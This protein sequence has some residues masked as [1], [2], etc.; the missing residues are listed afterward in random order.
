MSHVINNK[1]ATQLPLDPDLEEELVL[2][3]AL[4]LYRRNRYLSGKYASF[5][6]LMADPIAE[7]CLRLCARQVLRLGNRTR[8]R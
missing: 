8:G 4:E 1:H 7:R 5:S 3:K 2:A 6:R